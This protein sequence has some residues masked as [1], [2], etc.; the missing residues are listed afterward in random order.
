MLYYR[1]IFYIYGKDFSVQNI[2]RLCTCL[3][4]LG[5][6]TTACSTSGTATSTADDGA[7]E[8]YNRAVYTF[9]SKFDKYL[10]KPV[11]QGYRKATNQYTRDRVNSALA[12]IKEPVSA[13]NHLLQGEP[14]KSGKSVARFAINSTLGLAG[15]YDVAALG[16]NLPKQKTGFD[17][18]LAT[19][20]V[21]DGPFLMVPFLGPSTPRALAGLAADSFANPM[22]WGTLNDA[23]IRDK[24]YLPYL[25]INAVALR[26][27]GLDLLDDLER[28]SVDYYS[29]L[30]SAYT[31]NRKGMGRQNNDDAA[32]SYD[33]GMEE[34]FDE[35]DEE[36]D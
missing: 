31:Q 17:E 8:S 4:A 14:V 6:M 29:T 25:A 33:F 9:N 13:V 20:N 35:F 18:T 2:L 28:N 36:N 26:E 23:N 11:A 10:L 21:P 7:L 30:K 3:S 32:A 24:V 16:W 15:T 22:Y 1:V 27:S 19:W 34:E 12:N 5:L